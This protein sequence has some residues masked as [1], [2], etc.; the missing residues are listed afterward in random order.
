MRFKSIVA[1]PVPSLVIHVAAKALTGYLLPFTHFEENKSAL[2]F[3]KK[4]SQIS[5]FLKTNY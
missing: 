5:L 2:V 4:N 1:L 3:V